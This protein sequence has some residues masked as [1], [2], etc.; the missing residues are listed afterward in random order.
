MQ[1]S[2]RALS[3]LLTCVEMFYRDGPIPIRV[4]RARA[5]SRAHIG[6]RDRAYK[7]NRRHITHHARIAIGIDSNETDRI[8]QRH[9]GHALTA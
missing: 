6:R 4:C 5:L 9:H 2:A 8:T 1:T 7:P 3:T